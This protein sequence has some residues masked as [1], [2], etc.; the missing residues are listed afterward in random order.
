MVV[1]S[2]NPNHRQYYHSMEQLAFTFRSNYDV[3]ILY[4]VRNL[5]QYW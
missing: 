1:V 2:L 3:Y 4:A 5:A